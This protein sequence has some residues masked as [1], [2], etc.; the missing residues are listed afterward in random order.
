MNMRSAFARMSFSGFDVTATLD[1]ESTSLSYIDNASETSDTISLSLID[2]TERWIGPWMP[3]KGDR[4]RG[5]F[6]V[7]NWT[8]DG[9][10]RLL[11]AGLFILDSLSYSGGTDGVNV[12]VGAVSQ[13]A[14]QGFMSEKRSKTWK[15]VTIAEI[16]AEIA[17][18]YGLAA[19]YDAKEIKIKVKTQ[20]G[21]TDSEFLAAITKEYGLALKIYAEKI[22]IFDQNEYMKRPPVAYIDKGDMLSWSANVELT[23]TYT[24]AQVSYND[25]ETEEVTTFFFGQQGRV[26]KLNKKCDSLADAQMIAKAA[27]FDANHGNMTV[28]FS[29]PGNP[30]LVASQVVA[31]TGLGQFDGNYY[32]DKI[33]HALGGGYTCS[34]ECSN[35]NNENSEASESSGS[36]GSSGS[37]SRGGSTHEER[38]NAVLNGTGYTY[39]PSGLPGAS[40]GATRL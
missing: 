27:V 8:F 40:D 17:G 33:T 6:G 30:S 21:Q 4:I 23:G 36:S 13:P 5:Y 22:V 16:Q 7:E 24:G 34:Y 37:G 39:N 9:D 31:I 18:R 12:T 20:P 14:D 35:V 15:K 29:L 25:P 26:L 11:P 38:M 3:S 28:S 1:D 32:I 2:P 10:S 19:F